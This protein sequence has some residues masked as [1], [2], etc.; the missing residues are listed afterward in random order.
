MAMELHGKRDVLDVRDAT[1][2]NSRF[3]D[4]NLSNT[5]FH[6]TNLSAATFE[7]V[8]LSNARITD[9]NMSG[10]MLS[11]VNMSNVKIEKSL[12][13]GMTIDGV[14]V[15]ELFETYEAAKAGGK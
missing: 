9:A 2:A 4:V 5:S 6:N 11:D 7:R 3:D 13:A 15:S 1:V 14:K 10:V 8:L 12:Y